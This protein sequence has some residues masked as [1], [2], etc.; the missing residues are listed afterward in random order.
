[1]TTELDNRWKSIIAGIRFDRRWEI[2]LEEYL[3]EHNLDDLPEPEWSDDPTM[4]YIYLPAR[5]PNGEIV[6]MDKTKAR[7]FPDSIVGY[8][9]KGGLMKLPEK[10]EAS[11]RS[12]KKEQLP[13]MET[14]KP[15]HEKIKLPKI[16]EN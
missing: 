13:K 16:G 2:V 5:S 11:Q 4:A 1:M 14:E 6:R 12:Q 9:E 8:L 15:K 3:K 10:V 7:M